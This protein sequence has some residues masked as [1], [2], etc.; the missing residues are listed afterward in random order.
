MAPDGN[1]LE[2]ALA[3][4]SDEQKLALLR[5]SIEAEKAEKSG[6]DEELEKMLDK[7][8]TDYALKPGESIDDLAREA[9]EYQRR[10]E[11]L[12]EL[13]R[14]MK[15]RKDDADAKMAAF[16]LDLAFDEITN[17]A[18]KLCKSKKRLDGLIGRLEGRQ[19]DADA[20]MMAEAITEY[21]NAI[22]RDPEWL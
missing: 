11:E 12:N 5:L 10:H 2:E 20:H 6:S 4:M 18:T 7:S 13:I 9:A 3:R 8:W 17:P 22:T 15:S 19:G 1:P 16:A 14:R 21:R